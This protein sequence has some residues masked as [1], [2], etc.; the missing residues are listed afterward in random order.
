MCISNRSFVILSLRI[1]SIILIF[2]VIYA[3][4]PVTIRLHYQSEHV[5][6][7]YWYTDLA[8]SNSLVYVRE[9]SLIEMMIAKTRTYRWMAP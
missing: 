4:Q 8:G 1:S 5:S 7:D 6:D 9:E 2:Y 3:L